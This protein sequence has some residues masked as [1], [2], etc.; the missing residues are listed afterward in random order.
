MLGQSACYQYDS[1]L[2]AWVKIYG[3]AP[4]GQL[5]IRYGSTVGTI[6]AA[7]GTQN[8]TLG[9]AATW[10][11]TLTGNTTFVFEGPAT[12]LVQSLTVYLF[13]GGSTTYNYTVTWPGSVTWFG[14]AAPAI[15][16]GNGAMTAV[17][18]QTTNGGTAWWGAVISNAALPLVVADGGTGL[19][20]LTPFQML[21]AGT[22]ATAP[23]QQQ[24]L[25]ALPSVQEATTT[26]LPPYTAT[27]LQLQATSN[28]PLSPID[29]VTLQS[30]DRIL[31]KNETGANL[32]YN[33]AYFVQQLGV[34]GGGGSPWLLKRVP[35]M[36]DTTPDTVQAPGS[37]TFVEQI[38][39]ASCREYG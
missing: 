10:N 16:T 18:F 1:S 8:L 2:A 24:V 4:T 12:P 32:K 39:R 25:N 23:V 28:G 7:T 33:G 17:Q 21:I 15:A 38:G 9:T 14:G 37:F 20:E 27:A 30:L 29:G 19:N 22:T 36:N 5:D 31:V 13:Q 3:D 34:S 35:D 11:V 6:S 26:T